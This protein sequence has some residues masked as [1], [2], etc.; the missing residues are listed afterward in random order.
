MRELIS[1]HKEILKKLDQLEKKDIKQDE[2]I[3]KIFAYLKQF[4]DAKQKEK[5]FKNRKPVGFKQGKKK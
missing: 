3:M 5:D 4:V 2:K 1:T